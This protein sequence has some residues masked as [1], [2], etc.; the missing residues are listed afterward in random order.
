MQLQKTKSII[1][2]FIRPHLYTFKFSSDKWKE[3]DDAAEKVYISS[4]ESTYSNI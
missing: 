3:R 1:A 2:S 4:A